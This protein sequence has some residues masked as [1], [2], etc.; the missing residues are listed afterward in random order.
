MLT[1]W[2]INLRGNYIRPVKSG[3]GYLNLHLSVPNAIHYGKFWPTPS[4]I[5]Y[6]APLLV[7]GL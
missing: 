6:Y 1:L 5:E 7:I 2:D 3:G 4:L